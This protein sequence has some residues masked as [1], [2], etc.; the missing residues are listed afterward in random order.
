M[1]GNRREDT[2]PELSLR[3]ELHRRG[4]RYRVHVEPVRGARCRA[5]VVFPR[6]R[7]AVF[8]DGCFWHRCPLHGTQPKTNT[9]YWEAKLERNALRDR[10][11]DE[12]LLAAGWE[13]L[14]I[15]EHED[16]RIAADRVQAALSPPP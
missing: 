6:R 16:P 1:R 4:L 15:W 10:L 9:D 2:R 5:D 11:N 3:R 12:A 13:V 7:L 8:V 14:R